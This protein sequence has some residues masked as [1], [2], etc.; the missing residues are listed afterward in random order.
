[1]KRKSNQPD[2]QLEADEQMQKRLDLAKDTFGHCPRQ[3]HGL[4]LARGT[5]AKLW[6]TWSVERCSTSLSETAKKSRGERRSIAAVSSSKR[7]S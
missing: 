1:M 7:A 4:R 2:K 5:E 3:L 6:G